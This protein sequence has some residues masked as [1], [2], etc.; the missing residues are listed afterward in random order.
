MVGMDWAS[1]EE[2]LLLIGKEFSTEV[3]CGGSVGKSG[4]TESLVDFMQLYQ[5]YS[6]SYQDH[7]RLC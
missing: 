6:L 5:W 3:L 7:F 1:P 4:F 2:A